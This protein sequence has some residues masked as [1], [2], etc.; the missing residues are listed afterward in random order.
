MW[1]EDV[2]FDDDVVDDTNIDAQD[3]IISD[4]GLE[5]EPI[6]D[7]G[8]LEHLLDEFHK[9]QRQVFEALGRGD[10][11]HEETEA[12]KEMGKA[13]DPSVNIV[14]GLENLYAEA[15]TPVYPCLRTSIISATI[16]I[17]NICTV[18]RVS[19]KFKDKLCQYLSSDLLP[20]GNKFL[21]THYEARKSI[22][23]LGL[24]YNNV[25]ACPNGCIFYEEVYVALENC[26]NCTW[27]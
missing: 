4:G 20:H 2:A 9:V 13:N 10:A 26:P 6:G 19:N 27:A 22:R 16:I 11:L 3:D 21:G 5:D 14:D 12:S 15:T 25:H 7:V 23:R 18:F 17:M 1:V 24:H 8:V